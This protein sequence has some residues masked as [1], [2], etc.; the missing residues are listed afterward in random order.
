[1]VFMEKGARDRRP[2]SHPGSDPSIGFSAEDLDA[3]RELGDLHRE[4]AAE[5]PPH[6]QVRG[7][8]LRCGSHWSRLGAIP[9]NGLLGLRDDEEDQPD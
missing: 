1:L 6:S 4:L 9:R 7:L 8:I 5:L 3:A 2:T